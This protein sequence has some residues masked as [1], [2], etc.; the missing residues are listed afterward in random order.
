MMECLGNNCKKFKDSEVDPHSSTL[1]SFRKM[2]ISET[3]YAENPAW[4]DVVPVPQHDEGTNPMA[5]IMYTQE[6]MLPQSRN[7]LFS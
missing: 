4:R 2:S 6:C 7:E 1:E 3:L 5:P